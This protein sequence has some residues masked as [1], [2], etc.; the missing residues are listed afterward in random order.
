MASRQNVLLTRLNN[1]LYTVKAMNE[2]PASPIQNITPLID[3]VPTPTIL[4]GTPKKRNYPFWILAILV[5]AAISAISFLVLTGKSRSVPSGSLA[6]PSDSEEQI[7]AVTPAALSDP[8]LVE[9]VRS[10]LKMGM[11]TQLA[12]ERIESDYAYGTGGTMDGGGF[13]WAAAKKGGEWNYAFR[14][15]G[16]PS[17][18]EVE[19][20]P[21]GTFFREKFGGKFDECYQTQKRMINRNNSVKYNP[22]AK[23]Y[24]SKKLELNL[25]YLPARHDGVKEEGNRIYVTNGGSEQ[26]VEI[27]SKNGDETMIDAIN[28]I[29]LK[30]FDKEKCI[31]VSKLE[32]EQTKLYDSSTPLWNLPIG[33]LYEIEDKTRQYV[34]DAYYC[35]M[36][37][38]QA[39]GA[40]YFVEDED[41]KTKFYFYELGQY[42]AYWEIE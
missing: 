16:I 34:D 10:Y 33:K 14:G 6:Q 15:N 3:A 21:V 2:I 5:L 26:F 38:S 18:F 9:F 19:I 42:T 8:K 30:K 39:N 41:D 23:L 24:V 40:R 36:D 27:F 25:Y 11:E 28:R 20:F 12:I 7:A 32:K 17:C 35:P 22:Q 29:L 4:D 31:V 37:Y 13:Y 1:G